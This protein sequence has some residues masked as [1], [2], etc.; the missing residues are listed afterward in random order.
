MLGALR[1][2]AARAGARAARAGAPRGR[3][4]DARAGAGAGSGA[5]AE[6]AVAA[7]LRGGEVQASRVEVEDTSGEQRSTEHPPAPLPASVL[8]PPVLP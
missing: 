7:K 2:A 4:G 1:G 8:A 6:G 3:A 5:E